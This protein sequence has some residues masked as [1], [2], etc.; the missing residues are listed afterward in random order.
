MNIAKP[1]RT[2]STMTWPRPS[3]GIRKATLL[4]K[5]GQYEARFEA[6]HKAVAKTQDGKRTLIPIAGFKDT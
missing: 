3:S 5:D 4:V 2:R 1:S 6:C